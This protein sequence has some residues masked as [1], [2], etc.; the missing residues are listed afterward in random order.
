MLVNKDTKIYG[1][2]SK[3][4][5]NWGCKFHNFGFDFY[6][7]DAIYKSFKIDNL[8]ELQNFLGLAYNL[9]VRGLGVSMPWKRVA[10]QYC[11]WIDQDAKIIGNIN[12]IIFND[13][14][15]IKGYN[16]DFLSV[17]AFCKKRQ[18][19]EALIYG[20]GAYADTWRHALSW[21]RN[22]DNLDISDTNLNPHHTIINC[23]PIISDLKNVINVSI[24]TSTGQELATEQAKEQFELY[25]NKVYPLL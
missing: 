23:T 13:N 9:G 18:M 21:Y 7:I 8:T 24:E 4:P 19:Y 5:G 11:T 15:S 25:T 20:N 17:K 2:I 1:S 12:T 22:I 10:M 16:T 6:H 3:N 14:G